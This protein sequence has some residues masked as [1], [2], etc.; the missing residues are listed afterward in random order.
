MKDIAISVFLCKPHIWKNSGSQVIDQ[1]ALV[2]PD[3][4]ILWKKCLIF[5]DFLFVDIHVGKVACETATFGWACSDVLTNLQ[6]FTSSNVY[7][8][9]KSLFG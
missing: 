2:E 3:C 4:G 7:R 8:V 1:N 5:L 6:V 9:S